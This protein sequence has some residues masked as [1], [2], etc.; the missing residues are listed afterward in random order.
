M[1]VILTSDI[2]AVGRKG[3]VVDV[4]DGYARNFLLPGKKALKATE[5]ALR[6]AERVRLGREEAA[7]KAREAAERV[8]AALAGVR[9]V[10]AA[11]AGEEGKLYGSVGVADVVEGIRKFTGV[12]L[13]RKQLVMYSL[14]R[15]IGLHSVN[16]RLH[17]E[18]E[19]PVA[20]D[21]VPA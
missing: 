4:S 9:V 2:D 18:V 12:E 10:I 14:I 1:K 11:H 15:E 7:R 5:G 3:D 13:D 6:S 8:A 19:F 21:I 20:I 16:V 17:S